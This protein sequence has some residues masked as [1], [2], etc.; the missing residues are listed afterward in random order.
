MQTEE[1]YWLDEAYAQTANHTDTGY[2]LRNVYLAKK[3]LV[4]FAALFGVKHKYVDYAGGYGILTRLM[5]DYGLDFYWYDLYAKNLFARGFEYQDQQGIQ[6]VT[7]FECFEHFASPMAEL[8]KLLKISQNIFFSTRLLPETA[9]PK[10]GEWEYYGFEHGQHVAL[11]SLKTLRYIAEKL[12]LNL[13][14]DGRNLHLL[15][16]KKTKNFWFTALLFSVKFQTDLLVRKLLKTKTSADQ[17]QII[18]TGR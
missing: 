13:Y 15:T 9:I 17:K 3:T 11:Y 14:S 10:P 16:R 8:E 18:E 1:P 4:L 12:G 5:R 2:V 6:A 7:C